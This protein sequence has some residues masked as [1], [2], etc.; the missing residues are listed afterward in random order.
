M[1][2]K[3][4]YSADER[5]DTESYLLEGSAAT[6][7]DARAEATDEEDGSAHS[8]GFL[9]SSE[10]EYSGSDVARRERNPTRGED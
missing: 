4:G 7:A 1:D 6:A 3:A 5:T 10:A 2:E 9:E 8:P